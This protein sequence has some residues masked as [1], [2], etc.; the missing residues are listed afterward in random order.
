MEIKFFEYSDSLF[1]DQESRDLDRNTISS[2]GISG[3]HFMGFATLSVYQKFRKQ[4]LSFDRIEILCGNG[5]NGGDG[6]A[7]SFFLIQEGI[8][9]TVYLKDGSLSEESKFYKDAFLNSGG[10]I[11]PLEKF[12]FFSGNESLFLIDALLGTGFRFPLKSP[13]DLVISKIQKSK[14]NNS[15]NVFILSIDSVSGF[16]VDFPLPFEVD[17]LSEI[18]IKKWKNR[19]L[20]KKVHKT[21]H[22]IGFPI[23]KNFYF[24]H[25][26]SSFQ[27]TI[28][29][30]VNPNFQSTQIET[31]NLQVPKNKTSSENQKYT[32]NP[33]E[34]SFKPS[35][36]EKLK[37][38]T[39]VHNLESEIQKTEPQTSSFDPISNKT[40]NS[41]QTGKILWN[42]IPFK[43]LKKSLKRNEDSHKYKNG[44]LVV[45]G[46]SKGMSG[47]AF[48]SLLAF[49]ELGGGIS[50]ILTPSVKT[51][52]EILKKIPL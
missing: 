1:N 28:L 2:S 42:P 33:P 17:A 12:Q 13:F 40:F 6:L 47:A 31:P 32:L 11:L 20:P 39:P 22:R 44:S 38:G 5:N 14:Q 49:H 26:D 37:V 50:L 7:L 18:G 36:Y 34:I 16:Q 10:I 27:S 3:S 52:K 9:P 46:G 23:G 41:I 29:D 45:V 4:I 21:F 8:K 19:F 25:K 30:P 51:I 43:I 48:S 15:K 24:Q 35:Q